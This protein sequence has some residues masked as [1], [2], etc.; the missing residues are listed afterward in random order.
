MTTSCARCG[1]PADVFLRLDPAG[2]EGVVCVDCPACEEQLPL[3]A[4]MA[5]AAA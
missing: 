3:T 4:E 5:S 1:E 2:H